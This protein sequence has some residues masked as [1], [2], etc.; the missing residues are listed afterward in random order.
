MPHKDDERLRRLA[1]KLNVD[2]DTVEQNQPT[3]AEVAAV[4]AERVPVPAWLR[5]RIMARFVRDAH[6]YFFNVEFS[7]RPGAVFRVR[8]E[9]R[10]RFI[11]CL[12]AGS[13]KSPLIVVSHSMG[14]IL[15]YDCL[16]H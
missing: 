7:P 4:R 5:N 14:T 13:G 1:R 10:R 12:Q 8:D 16:K 2:P 6:H 9:M 11:E 15:A 3:E